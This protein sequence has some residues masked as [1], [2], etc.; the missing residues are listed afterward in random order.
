M[1]HRITVFTGIVAMIT[2][3]AVACE[4]NAKSGNDSW[5][6]KLPSDWQGIGIPGKY[7]HEVI[8]AKNKE[9]EAMLK[10]ISVVELTTEK[11]EEFMGGK[12]TN[13]EGTK[14]YL[15]RGLLYLG[16]NTGGFSA[17]VYK[18]QLRVHFS[19]LGGGPSLQE[20]QALVIQLEQ[21]PTDVFVDLSVAQ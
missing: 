1:L 10:E 8:N 11:A 5:Y 13:Y 15:V 9:A 3:L 12:M 17:S 19:C 21:M 20:R 6:K 2:M 18:N 14:P 7:L 4:S 16:M